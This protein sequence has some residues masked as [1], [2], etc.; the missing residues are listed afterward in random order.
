[1]CEPRHSSWF[2]PLAG[3]LLESF[4][5]GRVGADPALNEQAAEPGGWMELVYYRL[6]GSPR[7]YYSAYSLEYLQ[8]LASKLQA[9]AREG[10]STWCIFDNTAEGAATQNALELLSLLKQSN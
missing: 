1:M 3:S 2:T 8:R 4:R 10:W 9:I 6:H 5:I 7:M